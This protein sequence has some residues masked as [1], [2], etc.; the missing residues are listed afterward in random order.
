MNRIISCRPAGA[1]I[2]AAALAA[3][4]SLTNALGAQWTEMG[5]APIVT[6]P[7]TGRVS[8]IV[9]SPTDQAR[10]FAAGGSGGVWRTVDAG[11]SWQPLT[12]GLPINSIGALA[13]DPTDE[14][15]VY[16]G[17][18]EANFAN[19]CFYGTGLYKTL[20]GG[21][22]WVVL[23]TD[24]FAG[25]TFSRIVVSHADPSTLYAAI[26][27]AGGFQ[28]TRN[29]AKGH[30]LA[31]G[32]VGVFRSGDGG[33]TWTQLTNGLPA[34][35]ASDVW[36][37]PSNASV[38]YAAIGDIFGLPEN[39]VYKSTDGGDTWTKLGGGLPTGV[40]GRISLAI[41]PTMPQRL[42]AVV[43]NPSDAFGG[44]AT[45]NNVFR[46]DDGGAGWVPTN[47]GGTLQ[48]TFGWYVNTAVFDPFNANVILVGGVEL[49]RST[50]AGAT[51]TNVTPGH[52]DIHALTYEQHLRLLCG[53][54]GGVYRSGNNGTTWDVKN[55]NLGV[56]QFYP[57]ISLHPTNDVFVLGGL[58]DNGT[59]RRD[60][61][62]LLWSQRLGGD[63]GFT[64]LHPQTPNTMFAEFQGTGNLFRSTNGGN[65]FLSLSNG[66]NIGD[67]NAFLPPMQYFPNLAD[68][69]LY[70]THRIYRRNNDVNAWVPISGDLTSGPPFA[71]RTI[72]I[73]PSNGM[74]AY[75]ATNDGRVLAST[76]GGTSWDLKLDGIPGW[77]RCTRELAVD[78]LNDAVVYLAVSQFGVDQVRRSTDRGDTWTA[79]DG[80]LPDVP[81]NCIAV[82]HTA[83]DRAVF[84]GTDRGVWATLNDGAHWFE[85][86]QLPHSPVMDIVVDAPRNRLVAATMGRGTWQAPIPIAADA[87]DDGDVDLGDF[88]VLQT[89]FSGS[90]GGPGFVPPPQTC[91]DVFDRDGDSDVDL[92]DA[93]DFVARM[94]GPA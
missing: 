31:D 83:T 34:R 32:P 54:D 53:T 69:I 51:W 49:I 89:C 18:G 3:A 40:V 6:G 9:T 73:A 28:P 46:S 33:Q 45:L 27:H 52:V 59:N 62:G 11:A 23:A 15:I 72:A 26:M 85:V 63:G 92:P 86:G 64:A 42:V 75:A 90:I 65:S 14:N 47:P 30:P 7:W 68:G 93:A 22:D 71:I 29:A 2:R 77:P 79:I 5:P 19:H 4:L 37:D 17:S 24:T 13:M 43:T 57:G 20:N 60:T 25:R 74:V 67:R 1:F 76:T 10:W 70:G 88:A 81:A 35:P 16:A 8:A 41:A 36:M 94:F 78:P 80:N 39:G 61:D 12:D 58:Q 50:N 21:D 87:D 66:I 48:A 38:L 55:G 91:L 56:I 82:Q 84:L 44:G